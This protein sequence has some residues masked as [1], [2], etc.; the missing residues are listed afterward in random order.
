MA[1]SRRL[2]E[3]WGGKSFKY[4]C[5]CPNGGNT[6]ATASIVVSWH[7][8]LVAMEHVAAKLITIESETKLSK[9]MCINPH[10]EGSQ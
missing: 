1:V 8:V 6:V 7:P 2:D 9:D 3:D 4:D 10:L 5:V